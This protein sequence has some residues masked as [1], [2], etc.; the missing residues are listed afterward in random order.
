MGLVYAGIELI[1]S[2][3][4][5]AARNYIIDKEEIKRI[6]VTALVDT[7]IHILCINENIREQLQ[8]P[9]LEKRKGRLADGTIK[10]FEVVGPVEIKFK[11]RRT[12]TNAMVLP[13]NSEIILGT[14]PI[15]DMD[16]LIHPQRQELIVNPEHPYFAQMMLK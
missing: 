15:N 11:N 16:V 12:V 14:I 3:D 6:K 2:Y 4:L 10:E 7:G 1:N 9:L 8:L 13:G 5:I